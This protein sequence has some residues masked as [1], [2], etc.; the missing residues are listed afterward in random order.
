M[1]SRIILK[2]MEKP[3]INVLWVGTVVLMFGFGVAVVRRYS[4]FKKMREKGIE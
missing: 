3:F 4:E 1:K 2:A